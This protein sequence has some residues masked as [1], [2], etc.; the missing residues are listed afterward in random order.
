MSNS[1]RENECFD[2]QSNEIEAI[3]AIYANEFEELSRASTDGSQ[4]NW[5]FR[6]KLDLPIAVKADLVIKFPKLY[7]HALPELRV[8]NRKGLSSAAIEDIEKKLLSTAQKLLGAEMI[9]EIV[10][11]FDSILRNKCAQPTNMHEQMLL[12]EQ[13]AKAREL[14]RQDEQARLQEEQRELDAHAARESERRLELLIGDEVRQRHSMHAGR[15]K[16][17]QTLDI[18]GAR[19]STDDDS[20]ADDGADADGGDVIDGND[21]DTGDKS[22]HTDQ[23]SRVRVEA[24]RRD[25]QL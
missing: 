9:F 13:Q 2:I 3:R 7:P 14:E 23:V 17:R 5:I 24:C 22:K 21:G 8:E 16:L 11:E 15:R 20:D 25:Q 18:Y 1:R 12:H 10:Q 19:E 4:F 6:V